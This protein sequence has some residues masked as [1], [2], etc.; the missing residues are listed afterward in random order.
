MRKHIVI[1][2]FVLFCIC[3]F[4][5]GVHFNDFITEWNILILTFGLLGF[6]L[7]LL[8]NRITKELFLMLSLIILVP[9]IF[10]SGLSLIDSTLVSSI[11][12]WIGFL[13]AYLGVIGAI[14]GIWWQLTENKKNEEEKKQED[15]KACLLYVYKIAKKNLFLLNRH[16][17]TINHS[18]TYHFLCA[19]PSEIIE[20]LLLNSHIIDKNSINFIEKKHDFILE[21]DIIL[22]KIAIHLPIFYEDLSKKKICLE[23]FN[24][25][26][27]EA[28]EYKIFFNFKNISSYLRK[29]SFFGP[30]LFYK[31][32]QEKDIQGF[33]K[34][35][36][37]KTFE[38]Y[39]K[40]CI[41]PQK[42]LDN[43]SFKNLFWEYYN[44]IVITLFFKSSKDKN[45]LKI[46]EMIGK[47][48][49]ND[50]YKK[51][52][53]KEYEIIL[54]KCIKNILEYLSNSH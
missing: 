20:I 31:D 8:E 49:S 47:L 48:H 42:K 10:F 29:K 15:Y 25:I 51:E 19:R 35:L 44:E 9:L 53:I 54:K 52:L 2:F 41:R 30:L 23:F 40:N 50:K 46:Y 13:G 14:C 36:S 32:A 39:T 1:I 37:Q 33:V 11:N 16:R 34:D 17:E 12:D 21:L 7:C 27:N 22:K 45:A 28:D 3:S 38:N 43:S 24:E 5:G 4:L 18:Y 6:Y 26:E